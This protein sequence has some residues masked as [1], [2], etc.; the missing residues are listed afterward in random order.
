[1]QK[2][3]FVTEVEITYAWLRIVYVLEGEDHA[4]ANISQTL[5]IICITLYF[6]NKPK[7][8]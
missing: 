2:I 4:E 7:T 6:F 8:L 3:N 1:M 5:H